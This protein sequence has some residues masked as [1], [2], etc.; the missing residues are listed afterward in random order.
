[1]LLDSQLW[2]WHPLTA[3]GPLLVPGE[4]GESERE[5]ERERVREYKQ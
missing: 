1:M 5:R 4:K 2:R 3:S